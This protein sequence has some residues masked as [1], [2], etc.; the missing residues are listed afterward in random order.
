MSTRLN[1][2]KMD[3]GG[4]LAERVNE[5]EKQSETAG[6]SLRETAK[7]IISGIALATAGVIAG[8]SLSSLG[9]LGYGERYFEALAAAAI[10]Y[11]GLGILFATALAVIVPRDHTLQEIADGIDIP[12]HW[13][14]E[15]EEKL[16]PL[17][18]PKRIKTL[19]EFCAYAED[20]KNDNMTPLSGEDLVTFNM[21]RRW[22]GAKAQSVERD[23]QFRRLKL[24]TFAIT[25]VIALAFL[26]FS[27]IANPSTEKRVPVLE[28]AVDV[29]QDDIAV[30][31]AALASPACVVQKL[32]VIVLSEW[33]S[34]VQDV[35][36]V[37]VS[38]CPPVRLRLDHGRF[39]KAQQ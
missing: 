20:P 12:A 5:I 22:I 1:T 6:T 26:G 18:F 33:P 10:G 21:S 38:G 27:S 28:K 37:P 16:Q 29:N 30:L 13:Q 4:Y 36:T 15:I 19:K 39:S 2:T 11:A 31:R 24:R 14:R 23:L 25:P 34:G 7:W 32:P 9:A 8:T 3:I 35:V 17:L